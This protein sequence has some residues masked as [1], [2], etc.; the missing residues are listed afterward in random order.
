MCL[1]P[2]TFIKKDSDKNHEGAWKI[3]NTYARDSIS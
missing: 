1:R 3:R 2:C